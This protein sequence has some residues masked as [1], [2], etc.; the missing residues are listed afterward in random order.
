MTTFLRFACILILFSQL[1]SAQTGADA[2]STPAAFDVSLTGAATYTVPFA[3]PPGIKDI[4]PPVSLTYSS[5]A[6]NGIAGWGWNIAGLSTITRIPS[7]KHHDGEIHPIDFSATD[8]YALDGQRLLLKSGSYG[9]P[10][11]E[12]QTENYSNLKIKAIGVSRYGA[13]YGPAYFLVLY[14][15]G[16][17]AWYGNGGTS[18]NRLE[19]SIYKWQ[20][21]QGNYLLYSYKNVNNLLRLEKIRYGARTGNTAPNE[22]LFYYGN[23]SRAEQT[24]IGGINF[25]RKALLTRIEVSTSGLLYRKYSLTH[26][27]SPTLAYDRLTKIVETNSAGQSRPAI[28]LDYNDTADSFIKVNHTIALN[29]EISVESDQMASGDFD[30]DGRMDFATFKKNN[31]GT[32]SVFTR[33]GANSG[34]MVSLEAYGSDPERTATF[35]STI[36]TSAS[37]IPSWQ[38]LTT[39][40]ESRNTNSVTSTVKFR[41]ARFFIS[42]FNNEYVREWT[43]TAYVYQNYCNDGTRR[44]VPKDYISGDFN[45]DGLTDVLAI[46]KSYSTK[47]CR[48]TSTGGGGGGQ[49]RLQGSSS[50]DSTLLAPK[51]SNYKGGTSSC[52]CTTNTVN[53]GQVNFIDLDRRKTTN[54]ANTAGYLHSTAPWAYGDRFYAI[55]FNGDGKT[56]LLHI[57]DGK[58]LVY[59]LTANN[60]LNLLYQHTD[61]SIKQNEALLLG[62]FNGDGKTDLSAPTAAGSTNWR[63]FLSTG[64]TFQSFTKD[65]ELDYRRNGVFSSSFNGSSSLQQS[66]WEYHYIAQDFNGDGKTDILKHTV[67][68]SLEDESL[69]KEYL[70]LYDNKHKAN[71]SYVDFERSLNHVEDNTG[72]RKFGIPVFLDLI[73]SNGN[74]EYAYLDKDRIWSYTFEKDH[75]DEVLLREIDHNGLKQAITYHNL[76][77]KETSDTEATYIA[78]SDQ[79]YPYANIALAPSFRVVKEVE[80]SGEGISR[81]QLFKYRNGVS[82]LEGL[83]FLGFTLVRKTN[84]HGTNVPRLWNA[85]QT[86]PQL[87]GA[88]IHEWAAAQLTLDPPDGNTPSAFISRTQY[89]YATTLTANKVF[90]N[91]PLQILHHDGLT[92]TQKTESYEYDHHNNVTRLQTVYQGGSQEVNYTYQHNPSSNDQDYHIGRVIEKVEATT[93]LGNTMTATE[94]FSYNNNIISQRKYKGHQT[95]WVQEDFTYDL[96]GNRTQKTISATGMSSRSE[97]FQYDNSGR[98]ITQTTDA[99]GLVA[100]MSFDALGNLIQST[101][102]YGRTTTFTYDGWNR[103]LAETNYLGQPTSISYQG[104]ASGGLMKTIY[105]PDGGMSTET[106]NAFGW[107]LE[108]TGLSLHQKQIKQQFNYDIQG[109]VLEESE[110]YFSNGSASQWNRNTY[111]LYGRLISHQSY[112]G[113]IITTTYNEKTVTV[114]DGTKVKSTTVDAIGNVVHAT[115]PGGTINYTYHPNNQLKTASYNGNVVSILIDGW[116]RKTQ[117]NDP[118]AGIYTYQYNAYGELIQE[119]TPTGVTDYTLD[120]NGKTLQKKIIGNETHMTLNYTYDG[121][122]KMLSQISGTDAH[123]GKSYQYTYGYDS[124]QRPISIIENNDAAIFETHTT[125]DALGRAQ[126]TEYKTLHK[127]TNTQ[128]N[129]RIRNV[130]STEGILHELKDWSSGTSL[131]KLTDQNH[132]GQPLTIQLGNGYTKTRQYDAFGLPTQI[133]DHKPNTALRALKM[134]YDFNAQRGILNSRTNHGFSWNEGFTYDSQDRLTQISGSIT[135]NQQYDAEGRFTNKSNVGG[136]SYDQAKKYRIA[137]LDLNTTGDAWFQ[138]HPLQQ[139]TYNAFKNPVEIQEEGHGR[140]SFEYHPMMGRSHAYYGGNQTD[141]HQR[142]YHKHYSSISPVE[143]TTNTQTNT[144]KITTFIGGDAYTAPIMH[145]RQ[146]GNGAF[147]AYHYLHRDYLGS[148]LAITD[149]SGTLREQRQFGAWGTADQFVNNNNNTQFGYE[150]SLI[151]RGFTGHEHFFGVNLIHMNGRM[152]DAVLG[153]FLSPDNYVQDPYNTQSFNRYGYVWNNPL[154]YNDPSGEFLLGAILVGAIIGGTAAAF[155]SGANFGSILIGAFI[156]GVASGVGAG[157][158]NVALGGSFFGSAALS[159]TGFTAGFT[160]GAIGGLTAGFVSASLTAWTQGS[161]FLGGIRAGIYGGAIGSISGGI[162]GGISGGL[163]AQRQGLDFFHNSSLGVKSAIVD[164]DILKRKLEASILQKMK[165]L[166]ASAYAE[167][168]YDDWVKPRTA[169]ITLYRRVFDARTTFF[170]NAITFSRFAQKAGDGMS[171]AGYALTLSVVGAEVGVPLAQVGGWTS[172]GGS[173]TESILTDQY[174]RTSTSLAVK[175]IDIATDVLIKKVPGST[176]LGQ[177]IL[178]QNKSLK[179]SLIEKAI[180]NDF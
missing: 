64:V 129:V 43:P 145:I 135:L 104:T 65:I 137:A 36:L 117:L 62:D 92:N 33:I 31:T 67:I 147:N 98:Y 143:I 15:D 159:A 30:G 172:F 110:P 130:Y 41:Q 138:N 158:S 19:W 17:R 21:N 102:P 174:N 2:G 125:F 140:V 114:D 108:T 107:T 166:K 120:P 146:V 105:S 60:T 73:K 61:A 7:T 119:T 71:D 76:G 74:L 111:D 10:D 168:T 66:L 170:E 167:G 16:S 22:I 144:T 128:N 124:Y 106:F 3:L 18:H 97:H 24:F 12:Y 141:K 53:N 126:S 13:G 173:V 51:N 26:E 180:N 157:F 81:H 163:R 175:T 162:I 56:E 59:E 25:T 23:R 69:S 9:S 169:T 80:E 83:G 171:Y 160:A 127:A 100:T 47:Y 148:I 52:S 94:Q 118:S 38:A 35:A 87:R 37:K 4:V 93:L 116:G 164:S 123:F 8:R 136:Y 45:G 176:Q 90:I 154:S 5:Q 20:D 46:N 165:P 178:R 84:V 57:K 79:V 101:D 11:S 151:N 152:Y 149:S 161:S 44:A 132:R 155:K 134:T 50:Q 131:W 88:V 103:L 48:T 82:H 112:T 1:S 49:P 142:T 55:D 133:W 28:N 179:L 32:V 95:H 115:D 109:K 150:S 78:A 27:A 91:L 85:I 113:K 58:V 14:P 54:F 156:G 6:G 70:S 96:Y 122:T 139:I 89:T 29:P 42:A 68:T 72:V 77:I 34:A 177:T 39:V 153:R 99:E 63:F 121:S 86:N 40:T 75:R